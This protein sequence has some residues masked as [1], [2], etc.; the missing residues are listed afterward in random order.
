M[1]QKPPA[2]PPVQSPRAPAPHVR[3]AVMRAAQAKL[4]EIRQSPPPKQPVPAIPPSP[5]AAHVQRALASVQGKLSKP[6]PVPKP[7]P[8]EG[9]QRLHAQRAPVVRPGATHGIAAQA[10]IVPP[11][12]TFTDLHLKTTDL[13]KSE[14]IQDLLTWY[15][16]TD[17][18]LNGDTKKFKDHIEDFVQDAYGSPRALEVQERRAKWQ[19]LGVNEPNEPEQ[20]LKY[21]QRIA[22]ILNQWEAA[23]KSGDDDKSFARK[24]SLDDDLGVAGRDRALAAYTRH[25]LGVETKSHSHHGANYMG[26]TTRGAVLRNLLDGVHSSK[27]P[28]ILAAIQ[29][30][31]PDFRYDGSYRS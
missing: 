22:V 10:K 8:R 23:K 26:G 2:P 31:Y 29:K 1:P 4:P 9:A 3:T 17:H 20:G 19:G 12:Q 28:T 21:L 16:D 15:H 27:G 24:E 30:D 13:Q 6:L 7:T 5:Q 11:N 14:A 18:T 25:Y